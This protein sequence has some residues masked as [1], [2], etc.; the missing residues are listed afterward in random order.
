MRRRWSIVEG[1]MDTASRSDAGRE[2]A[3]QGWPAAVDS[4]A[5]D[6]RRLLASQAAVA[7]EVVAFQ[8]ARQR[9]DLIVPETIE[10]LS[11]RE[12]EVLALVAAGRS[13]AEIADALVISKKTASVHVANIKGKLGASSRIEIALIAARLGLVEEGTTSPGAALAVA[14]AGRAADRT[15]LCPFKGLAPYELMDAPFFFGR[16]RLVAE[17]VARLAGSTF[18][19]IVGPSGSGK[20]SVLRAGL[21]P[22]LGAGVLPGQR[23]LAPGPDPSGQCPARGPAACA[24]SSRPRTGCSGRRGEHRCPP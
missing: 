9:A 17:L 6:R 12:R 19:G 2:S 16:E 7:S 21:L 10:P 20:S 23:R 3:A 15:Q 22:A 18:L 5:R 4:A 24:P 13:D 14:Q 11:A 8:L 1:G